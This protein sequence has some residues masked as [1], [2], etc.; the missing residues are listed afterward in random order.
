MIVTGEASGDMHGAHLVEAMKQLDANLSFC[1]MGGNEL[2]S[3]GVEILYDAARMAV[4]GLIEVITHL[5]DIRAALKI[6]ANELRANPPD[7]LILIDYP[8]FN[9]ILAQKA[10]KLAIPVFYYISPQVWAWRSGRIKKIRRLVD[11]MAVILPFEKE[12]YRTHGVEV[13]YTGHP[14]VDSVKTT[15]TRMEFCKR[16]Q[17]NHDNIIVGILPGSRKKEIRSMLPVFLQSVSDVSKK[18]QNLTIVLP[19]APSLKHQDLVDNGLYDYGLEVKVIKE[20]RYDLMAACDCAMA[21]SGTVTLELA[22]LNVPMIVSYRMSPIT[23]FVGNML[24]D[25]EF[26]SLVNLIAGRE[27]VCELMQND[28]TPEKIAN[29]LE[30]ILPGGKKREKM[31]EDLAEVRKKLGKKGASMNAAKVAL[32]AVKKK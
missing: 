18:N 24:V 20:N 21:A 29:A 32:A 23:W 3:Q 14:L 26:G 1:G 10:K 7:L 12:F 16:Y 30:D 9:L 27:V 19:L 17:L 25:I 22:L 15:M 5:K 2:R 6:L 31:I 8:D 4:V 13:D 28:S 11:R